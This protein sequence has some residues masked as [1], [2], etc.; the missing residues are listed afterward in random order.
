MRSHA[1]AWTFT[2]N[3][4]EQDDIDKLEAWTNQKPKRYV[5]FGKEVGQQGTPHLQG[6]LVAEKRLYLTGMK[7]IN[8][9]C[10][11]EVAR[12]NLQ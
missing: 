12:G 4:Y 1:K 2:L 3:N 10:H 11:W 6:Y 7:K 8:P 9:K 5:I